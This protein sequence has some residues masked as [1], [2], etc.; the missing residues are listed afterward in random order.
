MVETGRKPLADAEM[1]AVLQSA[2]QTVVDRMIARGQ[3][4]ER[5]KF[6]LFLLEVDVELRLAVQT[7]C[8][9]LP[10]R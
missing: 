6:L 2:E 7:A 5:A 1:E 8:E 4:E 3:G 9:L 10:N